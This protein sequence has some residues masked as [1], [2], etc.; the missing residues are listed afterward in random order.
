[1]PT[2]CSSTWALPKVI[3]YNLSNI[4]Y[5]QGGWFCTALTLLFTVLLSPALRAELRAGTLLQ[6][7][8]NTV[9]TGAELGIEL[10]PKNQQGFFFNLRLPV[11]FHQEGQVVY[12]GMKNPPGPAF[13]SRPE[14]ALFALREARYASSDHSYGIG[15]IPLQENHSA[16]LWG[17][18]F[19]NG[20][21]PYAANG[22]ILTDGSAELRTSALSDPSLVF[23]RYRWQSSSDSKIL[24]L[25]SLQME[26]HIFGRLR[27][28]S[29][30]GGGLRFKTTAVAFESHQLGFEQ[31]VVAI[32]KKNNTLWQ[33][34]T[35]L[36]W[37]FFD[38]TTEIGALAQSANHPY[39]PY[40]SHAT[41]GR[42]NITNKNTATLGGAYWGLH[43]SFTRHNAGYFR[44]E[45]YGNKVISL[46]FDYEQKQG[47]ALWLLGILREGFGAPGRT[48]KAIDPD[49]F[50]VFSLRYKAVGEFLLFSSDNYYS[51]FN[52]MSYRGSLGLSWLF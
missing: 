36:F 25:R 18:P 1:M 52:G 7:H 41:P 2:G 29:E 19:I 17:N 28:T 50:F 38:L 23:V 44:A 48:E 16:L 31:T 47:R 33:E 12:P 40:L 13:Y 45:Y 20:E 8:G 46:R 32:V 6:A 24:A 26:P 9:L 11:L 10:I 34:T 5:I 49:M 3:K 30:G 14:S 43:S 42:F 22:I 35:G 15:D 4:Q 39:G 27:E 37:R 21:T 51:Y